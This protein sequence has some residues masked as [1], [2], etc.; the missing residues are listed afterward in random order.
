MTVAETSARSPSST[1]VLGGGPRLGPRRGMD[2]EG[3]PT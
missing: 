1:L 3:K 2:G